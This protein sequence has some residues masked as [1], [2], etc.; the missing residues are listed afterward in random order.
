MPGECMYCGLT[1]VADIGVGS[2]K[3]T[4]VYIRIGIAIGR[5]QS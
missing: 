2:N 1:Y 5:L 3:H 4:L